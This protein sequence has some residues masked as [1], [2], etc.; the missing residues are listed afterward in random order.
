MN[1]NDLLFI[2]WSIKSTKCIK[3]VEIMNNFK[4]HVTRYI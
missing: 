4:T 1:D 3:P 2:K